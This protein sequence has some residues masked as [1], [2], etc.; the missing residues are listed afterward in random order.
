MTLGQEVDGTR[1]VEQFI[2]YGLR[3]QDVRIA[4]KLREEPGPHFS[5]SGR[6]QETSRTT[7]VQKGSLKLRGRGAV[8]RDAPP[9]GLC[10][11]MHLG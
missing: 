11:K 4:G 5:R 10:G 9:I 1:R 7:H 8:S 2:P 6:S 3:L